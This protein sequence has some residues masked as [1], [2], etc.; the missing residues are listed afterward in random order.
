MTAAAMMPKSAGYSALDDRRAAR[1]A[2]IRTMAS[3]NV[4]CSKQKAAPFKSEIKRNRGREIE[5]GNRFSTTSKHCGYKETYEGG[6]KESPR[7]LILKKASA[8]FTRTTRSSRRRNFIHSLVLL[9][10]SKKAR[11]YVGFK[12]TRCARIGWPWHL[13]G[14]VTANAIHYLRCRLVLP[15]DP[16]NLRNCDN[17]LATLL[18][19]RDHRGAEQNRQGPGIRTWYPIKPPE[20]AGSGNETFPLFLPRGNLVD[21]PIQIS[22]FI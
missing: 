5:C 9:G 14:P 20:A 1:I 11:A 16:E 4:P 22:R 21:L 13:L 10:L 3:E 15:H 2:C 18:V 17:P 7:S 19:L 12:T 8:A 6:A